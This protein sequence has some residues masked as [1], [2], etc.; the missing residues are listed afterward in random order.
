[1][2]SPRVDAALDRRT[3]QA[4]WPLPADVGGDKHRRGT[5]LVIGGSDRTPGA[6]ILAGIAALRMG[7]GRLQIAT[8]ERCVLAIGARV[9]EALVV[10]TDDTATL[11]DLVADADAVVIGPGLLD[12]ALTASLVA[13]VFARARPGAPVVVDA[14]ALDEL[15]T[16][17]HLRPDALIL[18]PNEH[19]LGR[20]VG[21][22][23][24]QP[25]LAAAVRH[26]AA[27]VTTGVV[28]DP[29][30]RTWRDPHPVSGLGTSGSGDV[31]AGAAG[32]IAA[33]CG[34]AT[35]AACW[36]ALAHR[37]AGRAVAEHVAPSGYL[38]SELADQLAPTMREL[39]ST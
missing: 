38:A 18:T 12:A 6:V 20:L 21:G 19:E 23:E 9:P 30:G 17:G 37:A 27:V 3:L 33:R 4:Q 35:A 14:G 34:D 11:G 32:G 24:P 10:P 22:D 8:V 31:L 2:P 28:T 5:V 26:R 15:A 13:T 1:M 7:A 36:A 29:T 25:H 39:T 16:G